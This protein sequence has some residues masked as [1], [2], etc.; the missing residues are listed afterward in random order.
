METHHLIA[1][2]QRPPRA[3]TAIE[4]RIVGTAQ[5]WLTLRWKLTGSGHVRFAPFAG[6]RR[7]DGLWQTTCFELFAAHAAQGAYC[8]FNLSPSE[9]WA[10]YDFSAYRT[11]LT[12]RPV[13]PQPVCTLRAGTN[14]AMFD[15]AIPLAALPALPWRYGLSAVIEEEG[16]HMSYWALAHPAGPP[17]FHDPACFAGRL[18]APQQP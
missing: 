15:A 5:N 9:Q 18:E 3:V 14:S 6:K 4:A 17:D 12:D 1:H 10:A 11:G 2:P 7:A 8:E 16:G 13:D